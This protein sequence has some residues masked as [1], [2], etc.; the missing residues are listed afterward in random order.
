MYN[1]HI[2]TLLQAFLYMYY[3]FTCA[4]VVG[5]VGRGVGVVQGS[6]A[7][8]HLVGSQ[9]SLEAC[10]HSGE[11]DPALHGHDLHM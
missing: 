11:D 2:G 8:H 3:I 10:Q 7:N 9:P 6:K 1:V 4:Q 5:S